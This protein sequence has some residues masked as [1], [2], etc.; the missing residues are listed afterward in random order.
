MLKGLW[1]ELDQNQNLKLEISKDV[2]TLAQ[3]I[4]QSQIF[5]F[6]S[7]LNLEYDLVRAQIRGMKRLPSLSE[8]FYIG[9]GEETHQMVMMNEPS[10]EEATMFSE[11]ASKPGT[12][13]LA[14]TK[15]NLKVRK[16]LGD[17]IVRNLAIV[18][19]LASSY[20][21]G[22]KLSIVKQN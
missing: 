1:I 7:R 22:K 8:V 19:R 21:E 16:I 12:S 11:K 5:K 17:F 13:N 9:R 18:R 2:V 4:E 14:N 20:M 6:L 10:I 15:P 3:F